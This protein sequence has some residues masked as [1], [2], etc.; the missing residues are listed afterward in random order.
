MLLTAPVVIVGAGPVGMTLA[1]ELGV[2]GVHCLLIEELPAQDAQPRANTNSARAMEIYRRLGIAA[3][4]RRTGLPPDYPVDASFFTT[5]TGHEIYRVELPSNQELFRRSA[6]GSAEWPTPEPP[7]RCSQRHL[8]PLLAELLAGLPSVEI[9]RGLRVTRV[10]QSEQ[11]VTIEAHRADGG[12]P[13]TV[14]ADYLAGC[15]GGT[16]VVRRDIGLQFAGETVGGM[17]FMGG[18]MVVTHV[19][20]PD[21]YQTVHHARE[22]WQYWVLS[23]AARSVVLALDGKEEFLFHFSSPDPSLPPVEEVERRFRAAVGRQID[24]QVLRSTQWRAGHAL[25]A[26]HMVSGRV[27]LVGDAAHLFTPT[28]GFGLNTG[29]EDAAN[30]GWKLAALVQ[31]WGGPGL[32][33]TYDDERQP[34]AKRNTGYAIQL[35][36]VHHGLP[37]TPQIDAES[38][39]GDAARDMIGQYLRPR[40]A[41]EYNSP[42]IQLG[43]RYD[44]SPIIVSDGTTAPVDDP[45]RYTPS[46]TP[47]GRLPHLWLDTGRSIFDELGWGFTLLC[48][49]DAP[50]EQAAAFSRC[51]AER[52]IPLEVVRV[53]HH[54]AQH[55]YERRFVLVR[56]DQ[57]ICWRGDECSNAAAVLD[58]AAGRRPSSAGSHPEGV[59]Q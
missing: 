42:G 51:A 9:Q 15:D 11:G 27:A 55:I 54:E 46:A 21:F 39:A 7:F 17:D 25:V 16:S 57:H 36:G 44:G 32:L 18:P 8:E 22:S 26:D 30:L 37:N 50:T 12:G 45:D 33:D 40:I 59:P 1:A 20:A 28:G 3:P 29:I 43:A 52:N 2:R 13:V 19:R 31:G 41:H 58:A 38:E 23:P 35:A 56:P 49:G 14:R 6:E 34:I 47:G 10:E 24:C 5:L 4:F 48:V 53:A